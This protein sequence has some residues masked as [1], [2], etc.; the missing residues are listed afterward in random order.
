MI[1]QQQIT[2]LCTRGIPVPVPKTIRKPYAPRT[3]PTAPESVLMTILKD[4]PKDTVELADLTSATK[5]LTL[6]RLGRLRD[7]GLVTRRLT[8]SNSPA[9][10]SLAR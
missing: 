2:S 3:A 4:G 5:Q 9:L 1:W 6:Q 10:W 8:G 7:D